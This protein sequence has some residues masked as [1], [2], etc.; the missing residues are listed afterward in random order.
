M[1]DVKEKEDEGED[2][3][4]EEEVQAGMYTKTYHTS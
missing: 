1:I 3:E 4:E 2:L